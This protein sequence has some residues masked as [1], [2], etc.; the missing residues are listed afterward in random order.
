MLKDWL[1]IESLTIK[2]TVLSVLLAGNS[3]DW[4]I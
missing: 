2:R 1:F 4:A 3:T